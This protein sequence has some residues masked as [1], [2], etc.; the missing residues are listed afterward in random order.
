MFYSIALQCP[1]SSAIDCNRTFSG[2]KVNFASNCYQAIRR[3]LDLKPIEYSLI[4]TDFQMPGLTG[5]DTIRILRNSINKQIPVICNTSNLID[6]NFLQRCRN[7]G[8]DAV[9]SKPISNERLMD[10]ICDC[11]VSSSDT[12]T[13][14]CGANESVHQRYVSRN[15]HLRAKCTQTRV[16]DAQTEEVR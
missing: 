13:I 14:L 7:A 15:Y 8:I 16:V 10:V 3:V 6:R 1:I 4:I 2:V 9:L 12:L 11:S 5:I